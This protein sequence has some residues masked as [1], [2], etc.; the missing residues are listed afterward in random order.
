MQVTVH[1]TSEQ[2]SA[3]SAV[4]GIVHSFCRRVPGIDVKVD[5]ALALARLGVHHDQVRSNLGVAQHTFIFGD[6]VHGRAVAVV[7]SRSVSPVGPVDGVITAD[8]GVCLG[9]YVA[10]CCA[11][12]LVDPVRRVVGLLHSGR[13]GSELGITGAAIERMREEFGSDPAD[14]IVQLSPCVRPP[15]Y[16]VDFA[17]MIRSDAERAGVRQIFDSGVCTGA[18]VDRYYSY[19][20]EQGKT[21][22]MLALLALVRG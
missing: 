1:E 8:P 5:R 10:D 22:R 7:D 21:G 17:G 6:Q 16:E 13:K 20:V 18:A 4:P 15:I 11:V 9:V 2:F 19:R 12:F 14:L 3:L